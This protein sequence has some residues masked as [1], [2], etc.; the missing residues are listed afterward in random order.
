MQ[1]LDGT[2]RAV[3]AHEPAPDAEP[4]DQEDD[5]RVRPLAEEDR[6]HRRGEQ[7]DQERAPQLIQEHGDRAHAVAAEHVRP[8]A[9]Q[10]RAGFGTRKPGGARA[11]SVESLVTGQLRGSREAERLSAP[12]NAAY[13][14]CAR[15][16]A[17]RCAA[18]R[19]ASAPPPRC[20]WEA[21]ERSLVEITPTSL[22]SL[23][24]NAR[25]VSAPPRAG[26]T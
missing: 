8:D 5:Q 7:Q 26:S 9:F 23:T 3:L 2:G 12:G 11:E 20:G 10:P 16:H 15:R 21:R 4:A 19:G 13:V 22:P 17:R 24:T 1:R 25:P 6:R 18:Y 14:S